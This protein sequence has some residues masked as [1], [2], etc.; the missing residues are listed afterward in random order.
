M[1]GEKQRALTD[2]TPTWSIPI[3]AE[4]EGADLVTVLHHAFGRQAPLLLDIGVGSGAASRHWAAAHADHDVL[5]VELHRPGIAR[6]LRDL[7]AEGP[8]NVRI[9]DLDVTRLLPRLPSGSLAGARA[10]FPD[11]WPK[12]RHLDRRLVDRAFVA[13]AAGLLAPGGALHLATDWDDY[14]TQMRDAL[15]SEPRL[16]VEVDPSGPAL[17]AP[18]DGSAWRS[19]RPD[20]PTTTYEQRGLDAGRA[21]VDLVARRRA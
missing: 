3:P 9:L 2:L 5:A 6:L 7:E 12:R 17:G 10:L 21:V 14:A 11:P 13:L 8:A 19:V 20:R 1:S 4:A 18:G 15:E 16:E